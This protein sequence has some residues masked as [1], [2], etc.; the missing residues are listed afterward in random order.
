MTGA[1]FVDTNVLLY[2]RSRTETIKQPIAARLLD[3]LWASRLGRTSH[4]VLNEYYVNVTRLAVRPRSAADAWDDVT[5]M[6]EWHPQPTDDQ[7]LHVARAVE[8]RYRFN[9]WDCLVVA[10]AQMQHCSVLLTEDL[11]HGMQLEGLRVHDPFAQGVSDS[12]VTSGATVPRLRR[13]RRSRMK[14]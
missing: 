13:T 1:S 12:N 10:A 9:W 11:Q 4:Q 8:L 7:L 5:L 3:E 2:A 14:A 6:M